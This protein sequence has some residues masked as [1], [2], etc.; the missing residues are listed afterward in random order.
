MK[1]TAFEPV[2]ELRRA[3]V[4][5]ALGSDGAAC[6]NALDP[7][8]EPIEIVGDDSGVVHVRSLS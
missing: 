7:F 2:P 5:V 6:N 1:A 4:V 3:G 8:R